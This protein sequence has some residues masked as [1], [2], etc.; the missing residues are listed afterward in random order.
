MEELVE[1][2][3]DAQKTLAKIEDELIGLD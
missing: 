3:R 2:Y 1:E